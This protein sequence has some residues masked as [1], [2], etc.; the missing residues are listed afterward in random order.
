VHLNVFL[1]GLP[2]NQKRMVTTASQLH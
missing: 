2:H 1:P